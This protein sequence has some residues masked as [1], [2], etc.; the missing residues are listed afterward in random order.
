MERVLVSEMIL[1][2]LGEL[3]ALGAA[4][5]WT[6]N[7]IAYEKA[8]KKVGSLSVNYLRLFIA[9]ILSSVGALLTRGLLLPVDAS[10]SAWFWLLLSG[11]L[12]FVLGDIFLF[13][14]YVLIGSRIS[15]LIMSASPP[16]AALTG[17][18]FMGERIGPV[19]LGGILLTMTGIGTVI[20]SRSP[21]EKRVR[22][23]R[24]G[25]G[26]LYAAL[27]AIGQALG[28]TFS[29]LGMGTY[30]PFA[31]TQIRLIAAFIGFTIIISLRSRWP[32]IGAALKDRAAMGQIFLGSVLGPF[33]G[34]NLALVALQHT[35]TGIVSSLSST[36]PIMIIPVSILAFKEKVSLK[37]ALG[38]VVAILG[39][40]L[41]FR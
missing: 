34:V 11:L 28:L 24:P 1:S 2:H 5:C 29:K 27:G 37:E 40:T 19:G 17:F 39:I 8:G 3:A 21:D 41:L 35:A 30:N 31:S 36:A 20:L 12:G 23:N 14:A 6:F 9:F 32:E 4:V 16:I 26:L 33:I 10:G 22:F 18:L 13:E 38:A 25:K 15:L 7:S